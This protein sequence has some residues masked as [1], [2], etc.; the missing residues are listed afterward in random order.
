LPKSRSGRRFGSLTTA[1]AEHALEELE[2]DE[3]GDHRDEDTKN[4]KDRDKGPSPCEIA[5]DPKQPFQKSHRFPSCQGDLE[6][7]PICASLSSVLGHRN[8][9]LA[10]KHRKLTLQEGSAA[11]AT[12]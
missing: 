6:P 12:G 1:R 11:G 7:R 10:L 2:L 8:D 9:Y 5:N 4:D 3:A